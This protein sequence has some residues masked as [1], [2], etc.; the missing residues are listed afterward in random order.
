[1]ELT[2]LGCCGIVELRGL[3]Y[4]QG[5][6]GDKA[7]L[8]FDACGD[9]KSLPPGET[10]SGYVPRGSYGLVLF[11]QRETIERDLKDQT[12]GFDFATYIREHDLGSLVEVPQWTYNPN[13]RRHIKAWLWSI[14]YNAVKAR[15]KILKVP[16]VSSVPLNIKGPMTLN[17]TFNSG[18]GFPTFF[19]SVRNPRHNMG[20]LF[21]PPTTN[22][23]LPLEVIEPARYSY[24]L[25]PINQARFDQEYE[26]LVERQ[27]E[28]EQYCQDHEEDRRYLGR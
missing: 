14:N 11:S 24:T 23:T 2:R 18:P 19:G 16:E 15:V 20:P 7:L 1:M 21:P 25:G 9:Y 4:L 17:Y 12:Y 13:S 10:T 26:R 28:V 22:S 6:K 8:E 5:E 3:S 27:R